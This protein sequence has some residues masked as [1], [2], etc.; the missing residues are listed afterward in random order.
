[1]EKLEANATPVTTQSLIEKDTTV[2]NHSHNSASKKTSNKQAPA[3]A[4]KPP[5]TDSGKGPG[6]KAPG[7]PARTTRKRG[8]SAGL[9]STEVDGAPGSAKKRR[10]GKEAGMNSNSNNGNGHSETVTSPLKRFGQWVKD[11]KEKVSSP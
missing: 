10:D 5:A 1:M 8:G 2:F 11:I 4:S 9:G 7:S 3:T 6:K